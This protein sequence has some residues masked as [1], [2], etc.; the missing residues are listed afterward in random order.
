MKTR[1]TF[2]LLCLALLAPAAFAAKDKGPKPSKPTLDDGRLERD[3]FSA[4]AEFREGDEIDYLWV[5][6][7][8]DFDGKSLHFVAW[9]KPKFVGNDAEERDGKDMRLAADLAEHMADAWKEAF[10]H[11]FEDRVK[12]SHESGDIRV[13]GRIVDCSTGNTAAKVFVGFGAGSGS[14]TY[15]VKFIDAKSGEV[16]AGIHHRSVSASTWDDTEER[17]MEGIYEVL[18]ELSEKGVQK[19]YAKGDRAKD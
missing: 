14:T 10:E 15:D 19:V 11:A 17:L 4:D 1:F 2:A 18:Y 3:W 5:T 8:F 12:T 6:P 13:E 7:G 9:P 16:V